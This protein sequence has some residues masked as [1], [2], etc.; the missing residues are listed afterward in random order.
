MQ[1]QGSDKHSNIEKNN[2]IENKPVKEE[3]NI[4]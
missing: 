2:D 1:K 3:I 4:F